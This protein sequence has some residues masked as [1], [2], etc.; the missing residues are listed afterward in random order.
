MISNV[1]GHNTN[2]LGMWMFLWIFCFTGSQKFKWLLFVLCHTRLLPQCRK[3]KWWCSQFL[4][5]LVPFIQPRP[6]AI[7]IYINIHWTHSGADLSQNTLKGWLPWALYL[8]HWTPDAFKL[9]G[10]TW[11]VDVMLMWEK[12]LSNPRN[13]R[14]SS[15]YFPLLHLLQEK[16][17]DFLQNFWKI[18]II[19]LCKYTRL[20][21][22]YKTSLSLICSW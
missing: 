10:K 8:S 7:K 19:V 22:S 21:L 11:E 6:E 3:I 15:I 9:I 20:T 13:F 5:V 1:F 2:P 17:K 4:N 14:K 16:A 18:I 12:M